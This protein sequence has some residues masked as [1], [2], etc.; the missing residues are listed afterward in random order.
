MNP[1]KNRTPILD[2]LSAKPERVA[3]PRG[4]RSTSLNGRQGDEEDED[5]WSW[6]QESWGSYQLEAYP[7]ASYD[8]EGDAELLPAEKQEYEE[9]EID[10][11]EA[12]ALNSIEELD[13]TADAGHAIQLQLAAQAAFGKAKGKGKR[14]KGKE[15][16]RVR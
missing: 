16:E 6:Q 10:E 3:S 7:A 14:P 15:K 4:L 5:S 1:S 9:P 13:D 8:D 2:L 11:P 12:V